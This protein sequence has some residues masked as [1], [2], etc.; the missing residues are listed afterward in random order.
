MTEISSTELSQIAIE[1]IQNGFKGS[2]LVA[3]VD[4]LGFRKEISNNWNNPSNDP[5]LR[6]IKIKKFLE[7]AKERSINHT[8]LDYDGKSVIMEIP[9]PKVITFSDSFIFI[10]PFDENLDPN[11]RVGCILSITGSIIELWKLSILEGFTIRGSVVFG[12]IYHN[13]S[14]LIGP[15]LIDSYLGESIDA[16]ISRIIYSDKIRE[17]IESHLD[18][19]HPTLIDYFR[20]YFNLDIDNKI[21][22]NPLIVFGY[23]NDFIVN[24]CLDRIVDMHNSITDHDARNKY[25]DLIRRLRARNLEMN[26]LSIYKKK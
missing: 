3:Y 9:Y 22:I 24:D 1:E 10:K 13:N 25:I 20:R 14:D 17:I 2:A 11:H 23:D 18:N 21:A 15:A 16:K 26:D 6:L 12:D 8:F 19:I 4:L 7:L 5:L